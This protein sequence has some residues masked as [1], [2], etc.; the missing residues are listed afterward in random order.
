MHVYASLELIIKSI[1]INF[2]NCKSMNLHRKVK[3]KQNIGNIYLK[4]VQ[5]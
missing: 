5:K 3:K 2:V 1:K 4:I